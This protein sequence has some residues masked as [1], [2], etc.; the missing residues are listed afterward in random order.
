MGLAKKSVPAQNPQILLVCIGMVLKM[1][2]NEYGVG[3]DE[4][5]TAMHIG[6]MRSIPISSIPALY[7]PHIRLL[8]VC[9]EF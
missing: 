6:S 9:L 8:L 3:I 1:G 5:G 2:K 7:S 4:M